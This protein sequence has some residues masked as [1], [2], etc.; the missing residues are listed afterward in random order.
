MEEL[1]IYE[2]K[3]RCFNLISHCKDH[4][5]P[6][7]AA[8]VHG[9]EQTLLFWAKHSSVDSRV[10]MSLDDR[11]EAHQDLRA[12][13]VGLLK[14]IETRMQEDDQIHPSAPETA[15]THDFDLDEDLDPE[16]LLIV[17]KWKRYNGNAW[18]SIGAA[19][20]LLLELTAMVRKSTVSAGDSSLHATFQRTDDYFSDY[21]K[22]LTRRWF[23]DARKSLTDQLGEAIFIRRRHILYRM[24][25]EEKII[26]P[27]SGA[28][29]STSIKS[30]E[31][32]TVQAV[33]AGVFPETKPRPTTTT[34]VL[35]ALAPSS[36]NVSEFQRERFKRQQGRHGALSG[37]SEGSIS[38]TETSFSY[39]YPEPPKL[40]NERYTTCPYCLMILNSNDLNEGAWRKHLHGD[41]RPYV[42]ISEKCQSPMRL[43][44]SSDKW[45][46]HM[47]E[48][49]G[50]DW[51]Q[52]V[53]MTTWYCDR[54]HEIVEFRSEDDFKIHLAAE[55]ESLSDAL[56]GAVVQRNWGIGY[57]EQY[58]CPLCESM[59]TE[60]HPRLNPGDKASLLM[61]HIGN[62]LKALS[63][64]SL[65][66]LEIGPAEAIGQ[67]SSSAQLP[68][69]YGTRAK[70]H[71]D[72]QPERRPLDDTESILT[73][74]E[75]PYKHQE[76]T[77]FENVILKENAFDDEWGFAQPE[78]KAMK[79]D[80][81]AQTS[82]TG[83]FDEKEET[84]LSLTNPAQRDRLVTMTELL[85]IEFR[86]WVVNNAR[87][88]INGLYQ[89]KKYVSGTQLENY[90]SP[91]TLYEII[92]SIDPPLAVPVDT[93][94]QMYLRIFSI[95]V[96]VGRSENISLFSERGI[97]D[98]NLPLGPNHL[99]PELY[100]YLD[101]FLDQQWQFCPWAFPKLES[102]EQQLPT[103][104]I[105]PIR[106]LGL[107]TRRGWSSQGA[108]IHEVVFKIYKG[109]DTKQLYSREAEVYT[110]L[111][112]FNDISIT[113]CYGC[114]EYLD[115]NKRIIILEYS[116]EGSLLDFF[117]KTPPHNASNIELLW[118][119]L[120]DLLDGLCALHN[121]D[122]YDSR[123]FCW[124]HNNI[125][126][127]NIL[128]FQGES[129]FTY[130]VSFKLADFGLAEIV[131]T[132]GG[133]SFN[134]PI[135]APESY[136]IRPR[137][138]PIADLWSLGAVY[139]D[140]LAWSIGGR[141]CQ[142]R[143][144]MKRQDA[145]TKLPRILGASFN[146]CFHDGRKILPEV[147]E[148]HEGILRDK[149]DG[150]LVS[151]C[152]SEFILK[153]MMVE[154]ASRL[155]A[156]EAK[157]HA[158]KM[159]NDAKS[160]SMTKQ[161]TTPV[162]PHPVSSRLSSYSDERKVS[163]W[164]VYETLKTKSKWK[165]FMRPQSQP[166]DVGMSLPGM[167]NARN[168]INRHGGRYQVLVIDDYES[169]REHKRKAAETARVVSYSVKVSDKDSIDLYFASDSCNPQ[170]CQ[171]SSDVEAKINNKA[172]ANGMKPTSIYIFTDGIWGP[173]HNTGVEEVIHESIQLLI[174]KKAK[175]ADLMFQF[176]Q[177][178]RDPQGSKR[179]KLLDDDWKSM[180][181]GVEYDIVD[182][183]HCDDH[184]PEIII[185]SISKYNDDGDQGKS[186]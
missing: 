88:G 93:I 149:V 158:I 68:T 117:K 81:S 42:C 35:G 182:T 37:I 29:T 22:T 163:V 139:S 120:L 72:V 83:E 112:R 102:D 20:D 167:Q 186:K 56:K 140:F 153:F 50:E 47:E 97:N 51:V 113:K 131:T 107:L 69:D 45:L 12:T 101:E 17:Q 142:E 64:F 26:Y 145:I 177:F 118:E 54:D 9:L 5:S 53:H 30:T 99:L 152:M 27:R 31:P 59:P 170:K 32:V 90:W 25:H 176:I 11:L 147:G 141:E 119:R 38:T 79:N 128:V 138:D 129:K 169:M 98:S 183:K 104:Q 65:P 8:D 126:P 135:A 18:E 154:P 109:V 178:G 48:F 105:L 73:F 57:R 133:K 143:Y 55:H 159:I 164:E 3:Q 168:Q 62:H 13:F 74:D 1:N 67:P 146:A 7:F 160:G 95:L 85:E 116:R 173:E 60:I 49:H 33:T 39:M 127:A 15:T 84:E 151:A 114:F 24:K 184:V 61:K 162:I 156:M 103:R 132:N 175:P 4:G 16:E 19:V 130:D 63:L 10:G 80:D 148:F 157:F 122:T 100:G 174:E 44:A 185:G 66:S 77:E 124:I 165:I 179:L 136:E 36:T 106:F 91:T 94:R 71:E 87:I 134:V 21:A 14:I 172:T 58:V 110:R 46:N 96:F 180:Y 76:G 2:A 166:S 70:S 23:Q 75:D 155:M 82:S 111:R 108:R 115:T 150:D 171:K 92:S 181:R 121:P 6:K 52:K 86:Q 123:F 40:G 34:S 78:Q 161:P 144:R 28:G 125:Q 137:L 89:D 43:F 41:L